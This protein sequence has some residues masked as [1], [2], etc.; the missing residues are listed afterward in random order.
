M[1]FI[2]YTFAII[3]FVTIAN[4]AK[5]QFIYGPHVGVGVSTLGNND[6]GV[7]AEFGMFIRAELMD[8]LGLQPEFIYSLKTGS[9][10]V[11]GPP[12]VTTSYTFQYFEIPFLFYFPLSDHISIQVGPNFAFGLSGNEKTTSGNTSADA[13]VNVDAKSGIAA[14]FVFETGSRLKLG[15]QYR[16][17][18]DGET[19]HGESST[20]IVTSSYLLDW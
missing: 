14:G 4:T 7:S 13:S 9:R 5:S 2:K 8:R 18:G 11:T 6:I 3:L 15:F 12:I 16:S 20:M 10:E 1:K 19:G 17:T